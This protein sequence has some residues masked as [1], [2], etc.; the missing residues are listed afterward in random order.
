MIPKEKAKELYDV[1]Q[2][3]RWDEE[4]GYMPCDI[5]TKKMANKAVDKIIEELSNWF[6]GEY[7]EWDKQ[8]FMYWKEVKQE[9]EKL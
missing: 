4:D 5:E 2:Q 1:F 8:R 7:N 9:I 6:G 3:Y